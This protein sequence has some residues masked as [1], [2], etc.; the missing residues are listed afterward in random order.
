MDVEV[1]LILCCR[2]DE[3]TVGA[4]FLIALESRGLMVSHKNLSQKEE[5]QKSVTN[6]IVQQQNF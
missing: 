1:L 5:S 6:C 3:F 4:L 2:A